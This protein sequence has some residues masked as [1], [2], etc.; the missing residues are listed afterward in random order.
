MPRPSS[1][2]FEE[3]RMFQMPPK[4]SLQQQQ[5]ERKKRK[6]KGDKFLATIKC[7]PLAK[8]LGMQYSIEII[9]STSAASSS[10]RPAR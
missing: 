7:P 9:E 2:L 4:V 6:K 1:T 8:D 10:S 5:R 3:R